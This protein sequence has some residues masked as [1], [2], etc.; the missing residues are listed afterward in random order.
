MVYVF[1][2]LCSCFAFRPLPPHYATGSHLLGAQSGTGQL[3]VLRV[4]LEQRRSAVQILG[5]MALRRTGVDQLRLVRRV[6][7]GRVLVL[8][9]VLVMRF[10]E[11]RR[12]HLLWT[13]AE[14]VH[15]HRR[16]V[17]DTMERQDGQ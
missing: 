7:A 15:E 8:V 11:P 9:I 16:Q 1:W 6:R 13:C 17:R 10:V 2:N 3:P 14:I 4:L 12:H 5:R